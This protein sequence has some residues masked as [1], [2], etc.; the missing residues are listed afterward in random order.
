MG[1]K[2]SH[3]QIDS[4]DISSSKEKRIKVDR[5]AVNIKSSCLR[6]DSE[7]PQ[8]QAKDLLA[9]LEE[10]SG[11]LLNHPQAL[12]DYLG[13]AGGS[14][15][16]KAARQLQKAIS[17]ATVAQV[18]DCS[19]TSPKTCNDALRTTETSNLPRLP[20]VH[21]TS[22][23]HAVFTHP[24]VVKNCSAQPS[25]EVSYDRLEILGD[26]YVETIATRLIWDRF[27]GLS[28][29][30]MSQ[31]R[32]DLVKNET[33]AHYADLYGFDKKVA[34]PQDHRSQP[35]RWMKT[36]ADVFEAYVAAVILSDPVNGYQAAE[37]WLVQLWM[38]KLSEVKQTQQT[39]K[40]KELLAKKIMG[41]GVKLKYVDE[42]P[43]EQMKGG[44]QTFFIGVY[45]TGWGWNNQHLGSGH[46]LNKA[47]AGDEAARQ[48]LLNKP[49]IDQIAAAKHAHDTR[50]KTGSL[51]HVGEN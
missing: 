46:G 16:I 44:M 11:E 25:R 47:I 28:S 43:P 19:I 21:D 36:K 39:L 32:E 35:K 45:L 29:G 38:P 22:L 23:E 9:Q 48:A 4:N 37:S 50:I 49:L 41:K 5:N 3:P 27:P 31:V 51:E 10:L 24:G 14:D 1:S 26:A 7:E 12:Q 17:Q 40:S 8:N 34:V 15:I 42:R 13:E 2:R 33:L 18:S 6:A 20:P 30:R